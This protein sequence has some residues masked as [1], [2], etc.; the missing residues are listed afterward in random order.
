MTQPASTPPPYGPLEIY[1]WP[2]G[3]RIILELIVVRNYQHKPW[4]L[5][6]GIITLWLKLGDSVGY[7][8]PKMVVDPDSPAFY[9][10]EITFLSIGS[11]TKLP[12]R[13]LLG[14]F[15]DAGVERKDPSHRGL[16]LTHHP[17]PDTLLPYPR[18]VPDELWEQRYEL[19]K[20]RLIG[21][22]G[23]TSVDA[24][25]AAQKRP[26]FL[27]YLPRFVVQKTNRETYLAG[28]TWHIHAGLQPNEF[29]S[30]DTTLRK[31]LDQI[32]KEQLLLPESAREAWEAEHVLRGEWVLP[33]PDEVELFRLLGEPLPL[34]WGYERCRTWLLERLG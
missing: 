26:P 8:N 31:A 1:R 21:E 4:K 24:M 16:F 14:F 15:L 3:S 23:K 13:H 17:K 7:V 11:H 9:M 27:G 18:W 29:S 5:D 34:F 10:P 25:M 22:L 12:E 33:G 19:A 30:K 6:Q 2:D 28:E 20:D 32:L